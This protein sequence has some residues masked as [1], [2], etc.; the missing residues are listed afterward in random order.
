LVCGGNRIDDLF[1]ESSVLSDI[2]GI[3]GDTLAYLLVWYCPGCLDL[4]Y[5]LYSGAN[6]KP[7]IPTQ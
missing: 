4:V 1:A 2:G 5:I 7:G 3:Q 6:L